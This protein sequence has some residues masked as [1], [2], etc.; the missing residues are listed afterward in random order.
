[1]SVAVAIASPAL[2]GRLGLRSCW[3]GRPDRLQSDGLGAGD[4]PRSL[5]GQ[6][7]GTGRAL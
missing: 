6:Q 4:C 2:S 3:C 5:S 1:L 7:K